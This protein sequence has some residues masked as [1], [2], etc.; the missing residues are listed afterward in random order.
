MNKNITEKRKNMRVLFTVFA[1]LLVAVILIS[2]MLGRYPMTPAELV[3]TVLYDAFGVGEDTDR[4]MSVVLY[5]V[6]IPRILLAC[7]VGA[8]LSAAGASYQGVF[9]NAMASPD[10]LGASSG[11]AFGA[12]LAILNNAPSLGVTVSAFCFSMLTVFMSWFVSER[13]QGKKVLLLV[14]SGMMVSSIFNAGTS[15]LKLVADPASQLQEITYWLMGSLSGAKKKELIIAGIP[16]LI[17][18]IPL[19][20]LRWRINILTLGDEEAR[21]L[22][23]DAGKLRVIVI[24]CSTLL[25][26]AA[27]SVSGMIGWVGLVIPHLCRRLVGNN[28]KYLIPAVLL[29]GAAFLLAVDDVSRTLLQTEIPIGILTAFIGAPFFLVLLTRRGDHV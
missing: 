1:V 5:N 28:Y 6:R 22:G 11:A 19:I 8:A 21:T 9:Q 10:I 17:G 15:Y 23:I 27:V 18:I 3:K 2:F 16:M 29:V 13:G 4:N 14:L 20:L 7:M 12:A 24:I 25:T 26:A